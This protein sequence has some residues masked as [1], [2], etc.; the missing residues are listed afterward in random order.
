[1]SIGLLLRPERATRLIEYHGRDTS[2]P[3]LDYVLE[4]LMLAT[5]KCKP[6]AGYAGEVRHAVNAVAL[7]NLMYLVSDN[8]ASEQARAL[9]YAKLI[10]LKNWANKQSAKTENSSEKASLQFAVFQ[11][12]QFEE[13]PSRF[14]RMSPLTP[15][16]GSPIGSGLKFENWNID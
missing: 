8:E 15:P 11:I 10:E 7:K 12:K 16:D 6:L 5:W 1:M 2:Q 4:Q 3:G 9:A 14:K 13:D